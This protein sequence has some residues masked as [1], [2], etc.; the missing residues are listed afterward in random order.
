[1][2]KILAIS[3][4]AIS[5]VT[6]ANAD[7]ASKAYV[8]ALDTAM[9]T[10]MDS[11]EAS[12][13]NLN[14]N[15]STAGSVDYK[16]AT[17][18]AYKT[19]ASTGTLVTHEANTA[20][21][22][23]TQPVYIQASGI[24]AAVTV[25]SAPDEN[26]SNLVTSGGVYTAIVDAT[27]GA[28]GQIGTLNDLT[29]TQKGNLVAAIN[30]VDA[31]A[32]ANTAAIATLNGSSTTAGS[33][34]KAEAD[35]K[36]YTDAQVADLD[37]DANAASNQLLTSITLIDGKIT[38]ST[39]GDPLTTAAYSLQH[40]GYGAGKYVLTATVGNDG[41]INGYTWELIERGNGANA[42]TAEGSPVAFPGPVP[43]NL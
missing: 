5:A 3:F 17:D 23:A 14:A 19:N 33:V 21:G 12:I 31:E 2:K 8:Q 36:A 42:E 13:I 1:M 29:T 37:S 26:S 27:N 34:A 43:S 15:S 30:E 35:A 18:Y 32:D 28:N 39:S 11:A 40:A 10:R 16:I 6:A 24:P 22:S 4:L 20:I 25:D 9:D 41:A 7:I 38:A